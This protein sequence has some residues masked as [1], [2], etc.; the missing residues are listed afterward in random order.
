M[1][2]IAG[3]ATK[4]NARGE[5]THVI[6]NLKQHGKAFNPILKE[7]GVIEKTQF[8]KEWEEAIP[9]E[10]VRQKLLTQVREEWNK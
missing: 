9:L 1:P 7:M 2:K 5:V 8:E 6:I 4:K 3:V 10:V